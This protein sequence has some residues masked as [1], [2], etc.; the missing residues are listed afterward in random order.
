MVLFGVS[1]MLSDIYDC[2]HA[3]DKPVT[4]IVQNVPEVT[5]PRTK[6]LQARLRELG[7]NPLVQDIGSFRRSEGEE[8][9]VAVTSPVKWQLVQR[10]EREHGL[11]FATLVH[12]GACVSP[13]ARIGC[14]VFI[15]AGAVI[16]PGVVVG[17]QVFIN[18]NATI[19]HDT[20]IGP[21]ARLHPGANVGGHVTVGRGATIGMGA[22]IIHELVIGDEAVIGAGAAVIEDVPRG[23]TVVG[24]PARAIRRA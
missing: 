23:A 21:Y 22:N 15:G 17:D 4:A 9:F 16:A 7:Q 8:Y 11:R 19:G 1:N 6:S 2:C 3:L 10:L 13:F 20:A 14:G 5:R 12:P 24:V 18:R